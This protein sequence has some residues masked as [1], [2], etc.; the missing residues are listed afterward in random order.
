MGEIS[1]PL[2]FRWEGKMNPAIPYY[3]SNESIPGQLIGYFAYNG[4]NQDDTLE[5]ISGVGSTQ[6]MTTGGKIII[7]NGRTVIS[8]SDEFFSKS[9]ETPTIVTFSTPSNLPAEPTVLEIFLRKNSGVTQNA[10]VGIF[11]IQIYGS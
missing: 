3:T 5:R 7:R 10:I 1:V 2:S 11:T 9:I 4:T 6:D 8:E